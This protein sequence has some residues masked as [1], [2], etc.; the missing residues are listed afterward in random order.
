M[1]MRKLIAR[2]P[3]YLAFVLTISI[4]GFVVAQNQTANTRPKI[5]LVLSG[6][7]A[8]GFAHIGVLQWFEEHHIPVDYVAGTSMGGL[9][10]GMYAIG[11]T[12]DE[13]KNISYNIDW[14]DLFRPVP[15]YDT[16]DFRRKEDRRT[17]PNG[18]ELG[19]KGGL[20]LPPGLN[21]GHQLGLLFSRLTLP[22]SQIQT[23]DELPIPFRCMATDMV[24]ARPVVLSKGSLAS[25]LQATMSI[26][27]V[28]AAVEI[29]GK[30]L[31]SDGGL[32]NNI[33]TDIMKDLGVDTIIAVDIGTPLGGREAMGNLGSILGQTIGVVTIE[34]VRRN[35]KLADILIE[36]D[37]KKFE[38]MDFPQARQITDLGYA[39]AEKEKSKL[40]QFALT[41]S[42]WQGYIAERKSR[43][44]RDVPDPKFV[45][46]IGT[47][48][49][50]ADKIETK[51][52]NF[53][54]QP[55]DPIALNKDLTKIWGRGRYLGLSYQIVDENGQPG[56]LIKAREKEYA[57]PFLNVGLELNN[58]STDELDVNLRA[59]VTFFDIGSEGSEVRLDG[60]LGSE[61][62]L[63]GEYFYR[64]GASNFFVAPR[65]FTQKD[66]VNLFL[67]EEQIAQ[68]QIREY[69]GALDIGYE[70][71]TTDQ[72][73]L[74]YQGGHVSADRKIGD[75]VL[76][77]VSGARSISYLSW[78][79]DSV[80]SAVIPTH[81][82]LASTELRYVIDSP[83]LEE[84]VNDSS[85]PQILLRAAGFI[86]AGHKNTVFG[87]AEVDNSFN[88][89]PGVSEQF[90]IGGLFRVSGLS[91][92]EFRGSN[93]LIFGGGYL[94]KIADMPPLLGEKISVG[95][96]YEAGSAYEEIGDARFFHS[97]SAGGFIETV[98]GPIF[99]GV[100]FASEGRNNF[101]FA[102]GRFF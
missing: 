61:T 16:L 40:M 84:S 87:L 99:L 31:A 69:A 50:A 77:E 1:M 35:K 3:L 54:D 10:G 28:F 6:G 36:P 7:G 62:S 18:I 85:L 51:L 97:L 8:R 23:F 29:D 74:G 94:R 100:S 9:I 49:K 5:G 96:W 81:G 42:E 64:V 33:P 45:Q 83:V 98:L 95:V 38:T 93:A 52:K 17:Y 75:P 22:Y 86:P 57:P 66:K 27:G 19:L 32:L 76:P 2:V 55:L 39:G 72:V 56:L 46:V 41:D 30:I 20:R 34:N 26:P 71:G 67:N 92:A 14:I 80:D 12:P 24:E 11:L 73:R 60:S 21:S 58:T 68:Y 53:V 13:M 89:T 4:S 59:R 79:H 15:A 44:K 102:I 25:A 90:T 88:N 70:F 91:K 78:H 43:M 82:I 48:E 47:H 63:T 101:Y 65:A 37:L